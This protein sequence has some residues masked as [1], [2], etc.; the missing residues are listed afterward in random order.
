MC[1][2][3]HCCIKLLWIPEIEYYQKV[4]SHAQIL[5]EQLGGMVGVEGKDHSSS[6]SCCAEQKRTSRAELVNSITNPFLLP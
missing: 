6:C 1:L 4:F 2:N 5:Q 3:A